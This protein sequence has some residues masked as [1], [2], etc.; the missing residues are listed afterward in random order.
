MIAEPG[1]HGQQRE[2][3]PDCLICMS[4]DGCNYGW[5]FPINLCNVEEL[6]DS[7]LV[8]QLLYCGHQFVFSAM[9]QYM[10]KENKSSGCELLRLI[11]CSICITRIFTTH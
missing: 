7:D 8:C 11:R 1:C 5:F 6:S 2:D 3:F 10:M 4:N 9:D